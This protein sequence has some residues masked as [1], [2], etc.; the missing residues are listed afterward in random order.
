MKTLRL[1]VHKRWFDAIASGTKREEYRT[2]S[3]YWTVRLMDGSL[4]KK[5]DAVV[6]RNGYHRDAPTIER[7]HLGTTIGCGNQ[8]WGAPSHPVY[9]I[10]LGS[11]IRH[12]S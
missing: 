3:H 9:M 10:A 5:F 6:F 7:E 11:V 1:I 8:I 2:L 12:D 4:P